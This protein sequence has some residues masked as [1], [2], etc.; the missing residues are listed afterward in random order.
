ML[1]ERGRISM[2]GGGVP[3]SLDFDTLDLGFSGPNSS[4]S[5]LTF[6]LRKLFYLLSC[7]ISRRRNSSLLVELRLSSLYSRDLIGVGFV[8]LDSE[9]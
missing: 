2:F 3:F 8:F 6:F 5:Y 7:L 9:G 1:T 4:V